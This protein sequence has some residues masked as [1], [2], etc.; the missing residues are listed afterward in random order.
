MLLVP[1]A[2]EVASGIINGV[3]ESVEEFAVC[4]TDGTDLLRA[5]EVEYSVDENL[6]Q[7]TMERT[8]MGVWLEIRCYQDQSGEG[9]LDEVVRIDVL[10][11]LT[12]QPAV[13]QWFALADQ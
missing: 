6:V 12:T 11:V 4:V 13:Q 8:G 10:D 1:S 9:L 7:P 2:C 3:R 5:A